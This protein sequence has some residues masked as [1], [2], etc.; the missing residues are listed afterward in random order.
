M[1]DLDEPGKHAADEVQGELVPS[2]GGVAG[3]LAAGTDQALDFC[4]G[5]H[6]GTK[7]PSKLSK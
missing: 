3:V 5:A 6:S 4:R 2:T 7:F 1:T